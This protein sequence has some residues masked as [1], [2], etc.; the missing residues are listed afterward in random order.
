MMQLFEVV[1][2]VFIGRV[3]ISVTILN[4][5][6]EILFILGTVTK[7]CMNVFRAECISMLVE[8]VA[9]LEFAKG[10]AVI[11]LVVSDR[12]VVRFKDLVGLFNRGNSVY[13]EFE[14]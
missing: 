8:Y 14:V 3:S 12:V 9:K 1:E 11:V 2:C 10:H 6:S 4:R 7:L 13:Q 5:A